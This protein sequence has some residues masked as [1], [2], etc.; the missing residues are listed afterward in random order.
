MY[1]DELFYKTLEETLIKHANTFQYLKIVWKPI[2]RS[3]L[4]NLLS[5]EINA[6]KDVNWNDSH[7]LE[8]ILLPNLKILKIHHQVPSNFLANLIENTRNSF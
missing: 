3:Y 2:T 6:T 7:Y 4:V 1:I 8:N 5:L